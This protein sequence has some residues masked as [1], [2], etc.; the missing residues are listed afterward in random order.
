[1]ALFAALR[2]D[3]QLQ[4][5]TLSQIFAFTRLLSV[6]KNDIT[7]CQPV[8]IATGEAPP[9]LPAAIALFVSNAVGF[10]IECI[11]KLWELLRVDVWSLTDTELSAKEEE[12]FQIH[13]WKHG[14]TSLTLFPPT[15]ECQNPQC[16]RATP[17]KKPEAR[18]I[19]VYTLNK[20][21][22][23]AW[24][25]HLYCPECHTNYHHNYSVCAGMR[26][27][28]GDTPKYLQMGEHQFAERR[29]M[30]MWITLML[31]AWYSRVSATDCARSYDMA[32][33]KQQEH[34]FA[35]GGWQFGCSLTPDHIWDTFTLLTLLDYN[36]CKDMCLHVPHTGKTGSQK[37]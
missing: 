21:A 25:V 3:P 20:G 27:Y 2:R 15:H 8:N 37:L 4:G 30:G 9:V 24:T 33:S 35:D 26:T 29:V 14:L 28:Y 10:A 31:V 13:G 17:L 19:V 18:Q 36:D 7:L 11:P 1:M 5:V 22:V 12:L 6:L 32:L 34:D 16:S 23:P